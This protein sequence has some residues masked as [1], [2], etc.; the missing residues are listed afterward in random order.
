MTPTQA[1][2]SLALF[3]LVAQDVTGQA[4]YQKPPQAILD[5]LNAD[6]PPSVSLNPTRDTLLL[7]QSARYPGIAE[8]AEPQLRLAGFRLNPKTSGPARPAKV[9]ALTLM[10]VE[11]G[12][13]RPI[14]LPKGKVGIPDWSPDGKRLALAVTTDDAIELWVGDVE[15]AKLRKIPGVTLNATLGD[16]ILWLADSNRIQVRTVPA[17]RGKVPE[18]PL[19]PLGPTIQETAGKAGPVRTYQDMLQ[20][21]HDEALFEYFATSQL[22]VVDFATGAVQP[23]GPPGLYTSSSHSPDGKYRLVTRL[24]RPFSYLYPAS[25]FPKVVEVWDENAKVVR[26]IADLPLQDKVPIEG[27]PTGPRNVAW[28]PTK[29]ATLY[30]VEAQDGGDPKVKVAPRDIVVKLG[31]PFVGDAALQN[32][33]EHRF[34]GLQFMPDGDR[35]WLTDYDRDRRWSRTVSVN[36][37]T[38]D[39]ADADVFKLI[40]FSR[41][42]QDRYNDPGT[43]LSKRMPNGRVALW[44]VNKKVFFAGSGAS[45]KGDRPFLDRCDPSDLGHRPERLFQCGDGEY[46]TATPLTDDGTKLLVRR[47]SPTDPGNYFYRVGDKETAIT[48]FVDPAPVL[49]GIKKQLVTTKRADGVPVSFTLYLPPDY[50]DGEKRP[51]IFWAYPREFN[52]ADTA[53]QVTGST[54]RFT[55]IAGYSHLFFLLQGYVVMDEVSVPIVG[56]PDKAND[57]FVEQLVGSAKAAIDKAVEMGPVDRDRIGVGGHSY[58]AFMTAN[59]L[60]HSDL[61]RAGIARSGAYNRTLT[62]FGFQNERRTFWEAPGVYATMS[63]FNNVTK[64]NEPILLIHGAADDNPGTFP[65]Q[66]E[67]LYQAIRGNNGTARL[68]LLPHESHGYAAKETIEHVL[69]EQVAWFDKYVKAAKPR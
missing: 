3:A 42:I 32:R 22:A 7:I 53:G 64:I 38:P 66:S 18:A 45:P 63:P 1:A 69:A 15:T 6:L 36:L 35:A 47:E 46:A 58:G 23:S 65:V 19:A 11:G 29:D 41:S 40:L 44:S 33:V 50:K 13:P 43:P 48:T 21:A 9:T 55:T 4:T 51:T 30:W 60:A 59:L 10:P 24:K 27:V 16:P 8:L 17:N 34:S 14:E 62:P 57:T 52:T 67:R 31:A 39:T 56:P 37:S 20:N 26:T 5:V 25:S 49:R 28:I 61:F 12:H 68:V 2:V 54:N